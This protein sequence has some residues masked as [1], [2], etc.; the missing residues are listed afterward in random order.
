MRG[1]RKYVLKTYI[2]GQRVKGCPHGYDGVADCKTVRQEWFDLIRQGESYVVM[3]MFKFF[4]TRA[5]G[6]RFFSLLILKYSD[7]YD[8]GYF[9]PKTS[10]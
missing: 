10:F 3:H 1:A 7:N 9:D 5:F 4:T 2:D 8:L 6:K